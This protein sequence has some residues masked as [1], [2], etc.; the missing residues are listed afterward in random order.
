MGVGHGLTILKK[1][2]QILSRDSG[3]HVQQ[4]MDL[5]TTEPSAK[6]HSLVF[7]SMEMGTREHEFRVTSTRINT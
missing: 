5:G 6:P 4:S 2:A 7:S 1:S 3:K